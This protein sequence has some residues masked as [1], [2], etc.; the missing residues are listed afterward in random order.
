MFTTELLRRADHPIEVERTYDV[1]GAAAF[2]WREHNSIPNAVAIRFSLCRKS[3]V[4][5]RGNK[6]AAHY[7]NGWRQESVQ[8]GDPPLRFIAAIGQI[9]VRALRQRMNTRIGP[10]GAMHPDRLGTD[11]QKSAFQMVLDRIAV[12]LTLPSG[13]RGTVV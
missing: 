11:T 9:H 13:K 2:K 10:S 4:E 5:R 8:R 6:L 3:R 1:P 7:A 12:R